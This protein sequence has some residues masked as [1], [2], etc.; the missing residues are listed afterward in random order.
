MVVT[1]GFQVGPQSTR[2]ATRRWHSASDIKEMSRW[3]LALRQ[4][5]LLEAVCDECGPDTEPRI[6]WGRGADVF[7]GILFGNQRER[8]ADCLQSY[9]QSC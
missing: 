1:F 8:D 5:C 6:W 2:N 9:N 4:G 3:V 7:R